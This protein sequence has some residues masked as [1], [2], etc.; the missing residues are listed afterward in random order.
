[1]PP[2]TIRT[3]RED[4][5]PQLFASRQAA[6]NDASDF[7]EPRTRQRHLER[8]AFTRGA[9]VGDTL[10]SVAAMFPFKV[11]FAGTLVSAGGLASVQTPPEHRRK[12]YVASLL[13]D[14]LERLRDEGVGWCLEHPFDPRFY[15]RYGWQTVAAGVTLSVPPEA[16]LTRAADVAA[17]RV[18]P[19]DDKTLASLH[20]IY[21]AFA[22]RYQFPLSR[23]DASKRGWPQVLRHPWTAR[24]MLVYRLDDAYAVLE[25]ESDRVT[26]RDYAYRTPA[27]RRQL[28]AFLGLFAGQVERVTLTVPLGD[29]ALLEHPREIAAGR[30]HTLLQARIV[31]LHAALAPICSER[32]DVLTLRLSDLFCPWN[33]GTFALELSPEGCRV[34][35]STRAPEVSLD[36]RTLTALVSGSL[37]ARAAYHSGRLEGREQDAFRLDALS[38]GRVPYFSVGDYF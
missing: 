36:I 37:S 5:L 26:V 10:V 18:D 15:A 11:H 4:D 1:M 38:Q 24:E 34:S 14:G 13:Q 17:K 9:F 19:V 29:P 7:S 16:F 28:F 6:Y 23:D 3:L 2:L 33:D 20:A 31:T 22:A 25:L 8:L 30:E 21:Q 27:A 35:P 32:E 12:G